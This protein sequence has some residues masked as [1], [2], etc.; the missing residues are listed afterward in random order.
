M[1]VSSYGAGTKTSGVVKIIKDDIEITINEEGI[2]QKCDAF[3][4]HF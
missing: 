4:P 2:F 3:T 1:S